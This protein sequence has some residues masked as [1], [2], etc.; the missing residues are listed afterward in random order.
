MNN[1]IEVTFKFFSGIH[2]EISLPSYDPAEGLKVTLKKG[3]RLKKALKEM[4]LQNLSSNAYFSGG[5]RIGLWKKLKD[6]EEISCLKPSG[7][8]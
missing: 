1:K 2:K 3:T 8:G 5:E 7:G 4:G 6:G